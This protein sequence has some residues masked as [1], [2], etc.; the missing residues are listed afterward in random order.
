MGHVPPVTYRLV[1][2]R[3]GLQYTPGHIAER[4]NQA[5][6]RDAKER[7]LV[8]PTLGWVGTW[9]WGRPAQDSRTAGGMVVRLLQFWA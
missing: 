7:V 6:P 1:D 9:G 5:K 8:R 3:E 4:A 2:M